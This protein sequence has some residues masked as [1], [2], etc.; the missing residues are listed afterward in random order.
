MRILLCGDTPG[1]SQLLAHVPLQNVVGIIAATIRPQYLKTL[2]SLAKTEKV[3]LLVQPKWKS[4]RYDEFLRKIIQSKPD[5]ILVNSYSMIIREDVLS[6]SRLGGINVHGALLPRNRGCNPTQWAILN[7]EYETGVT[8]HQMDSGIDTGPIIDQRKIPI[9]FHDSWLDVRE[10]EVQVTNDLLKSNVPGILLGN[11]KAIPQRK[12]NATTGRRRTPEDGEFFWSEKIIDIHN[13]I[14]A[15]LPPLPCAFYRNQNDE[16]TELPQYQTPWQLT[17]GKYG[18]KSKDEFIQSENIRLLPLQ[19]K[20]SDLLDDWNLDT[21]LPF[22]DSNYGPNS[23]ENQGAWIE[24][25]MTKRSDLIIFA[26]EE[27]EHSKPIGT[28]SLHNINWRNRSSEVQVRIK[29]SEYFSQSY[30]IEAVNLLCDF[31]FDDLNLHR[32]YLHIF[33]DNKNAIRAYEQIGFV[34]E[35]CHKEPAFSDG[36]W[37][38]IL[39]MSKI[40]K[41]E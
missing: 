8:L 28:C 29:D 21:V 5:L 37:R 34:K 23:G 18:E 11:W 15:L 40:E 2:E 26:I 36:S 17:V 12:E 14:R 38:D 24:R 10:R 35:G 39:Y 27:M 16:S 7:Q 13:K 6:A 25:M 41:N 20:D 1:V 32:V 31:G 30:E 19:K 9:F 3:S 33:A 22:G 4:E